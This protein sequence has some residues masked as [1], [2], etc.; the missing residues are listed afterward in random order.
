MHA[1]QAQGGAERAHR[2]CEDMSLTVLGPGDHREDHHEDHH[3]LA[4]TDHTTCEAVTSTWGLDQELETSA[5]NNSRNN[6]RSNSNSA[7]ILGEPGLG[8]RI[9][10]NMPPTK[11]QLV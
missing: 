1:A 5:C 10:P 2:E 7:R 3:V 8:D 6:N 11:F 4:T 9:R